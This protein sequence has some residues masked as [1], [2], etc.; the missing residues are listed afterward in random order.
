M[1]ALKREDCSYKTV[2]LFSNL[3]FVRVLSIR[4][5]KD[6]YQCWYS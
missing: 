3:R 2:L 6:D 5:D 1:V 4:R